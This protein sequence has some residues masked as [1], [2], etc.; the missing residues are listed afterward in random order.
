[1]GGY[2]SGRPASFRHSTVEDSVVLRMAAV[3][4]TGALTSA[5]IVSNKGYPLWVGP[6]VGWVQL[7]IQAGN[8][9]VLVLAYLSCG[10]GQHRVVIS[11]V[12]PLATTRPA[13]GGLRWWI[14]CH[15]GRRVANLYLPSEE[16]YFRCRTCHQLT[17][18]CR[19]EDAP[20]R[21]RRRAKKLLRRL[22]NAK[23]S[24]G[25]PKGMRHITYELIRLRA[26]ELELEATKAIC[27]KSF[28]G[29]SASSHAKAGAKRL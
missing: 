8:R 12:Y 9:P 28:W 24:E 11:E 16:Y 5:G 23:S 3:Y 27:S 20:D 17:Y 6:L 18:T 22:G 14:V 19:R 25:R 13:F 7:T 15:C 10:P 29:S 1:M 4:R 2:G 21:L 26:A